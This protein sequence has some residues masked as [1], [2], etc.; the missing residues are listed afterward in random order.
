[1]KSKLLNVLLLLTSLVGY[2]EWGQNR[3]MFLFQLEA[4]IFTK[5]LR[6]SVSILHPFILLPFLGQVLLLITLFQKNPGKKL[7]Y[8][9]IGAIGIL[10]A[11]VLLIGCLNLNLWI[12]ISA[13]PFF[14]ISFITIRLNLKMRID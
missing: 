9:G 12:I 8:I 6:D 10:M 5:F 11:L 7:T 1:M 2:L 14:V 4:E 3:K 13:I